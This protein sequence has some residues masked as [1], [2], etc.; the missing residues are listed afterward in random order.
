MKV[1]D[2]IEELLKYDQDMKVIIDDGS[3]LSSIKKLQK[4]REAIWITVKPDRDYQKFQLALWQ[5]NNDRSNND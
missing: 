5:K 3:E 4:L 2:L 1:K